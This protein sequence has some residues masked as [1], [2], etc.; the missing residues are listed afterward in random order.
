MFCYGKGDYSLKD[1]VEKG[2]TTKEKFDFV[3]Q[4]CDG[5]AFIHNNGETHR[6]I[7]PENILIKITLLKLQIL[8]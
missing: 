3:L 6:D 4:V 1:A 2:L 7:K 5:L 8:E